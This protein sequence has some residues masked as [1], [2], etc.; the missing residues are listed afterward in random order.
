V[1]SGATVTFTITVTNTGDVPLTNVHVTDALAPDCVRN[2]LGTLQ[3]GQSAPA[4]TCTLANV[5]A[6]FTNSATAIGTPPSGPD[7]TA[8]DTAP[9]QVIHPAIQIVKD[10]DQTVNSGGTATFTIRVT[11]T[12]DVTLTNVQVSDALAPD[13]VRNNLGTLAAGASTTYTC[14]V[15]NVTAGFTNSATATGHPPVGP[16]VTS[17]DTAVVTVPTAN[18][19]SCCSGGESTTHPAIDVQKTPDT[20]T[21]VSGATVTFTIT[22]KNT[23]DV[24][25]TN[26][27]VT[28]AQAPDCAR[29]NLGTLNAGASTSYT[30][31]LANVTGSFTNSA[32]AFGTPPS[33][34][35]VQHTDTADVHV[36]HPAIQLT[37]DPDQTVASGGTATFTITVKNTGDATIAGLQVTDDLAPGCA[38][39]GTNNLGALD[40]GQSTSYT[41]T[42]AN[43][44]AALTNSATVTGSPPVGPSVTST[45]TARVDVT[46]PPVPPTPTSEVLA[47]RP[48]PPVAPTEI[49]A[50]SPPEQP[51]PTPLPPIALPKTGAPLSTGLGHESTLLG[52]V[53]LALAGAGIGLRRRAGRHP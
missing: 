19:S 50:V 31:T 46:T 42:M 18:V 5:T 41:C 53:F 14:S 40:P 10:P 7:V 3:P 44:T 51:V 28:D 17:T 30:C 2:D 8:T 33:G 11:N 32:T 47:A 43:V 16:D 12:G 6:S 13:C 4:Y 29:S 23:G 1:V 52:V 37:K 36:I 9:V 48:Q 22:V 21:V 49:E 45:D 15:A 20:Q 24:T 38:R 35:D 39:T 26:V 34:G 27:H 25:L